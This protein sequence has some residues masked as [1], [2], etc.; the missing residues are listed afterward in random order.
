M[1]YLHVD[2]ILVLLCLKYLQV[3]V[4][5]KSASSELTERT[6]NDVAG[7]LILALSMKMVI[8]FILMSKKSLSYLC[9]YQETSMEQGWN[10]GLVKVYG[11]TGFNEKVIIF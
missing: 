9:R 5:M 10:I 8:D 1:G 2:S 3:K 7:M 4:G 11:K 6:M